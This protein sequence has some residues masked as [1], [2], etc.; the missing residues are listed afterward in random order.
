M[1]TRNI[2]GKRNVNGTISGFFYREMKIVT[3]LYTHPS[4]K[5][6][7]MTKLKKVGD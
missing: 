6:E 5:Q 3:V 2:F 1:I 4:L 7:K